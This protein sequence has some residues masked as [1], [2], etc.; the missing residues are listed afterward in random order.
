M[1]LE[2]LTYTSITGGCSIYTSLESSCP[3][4]SSEPSTEALAIR[5]DLF[6]AIPTPVAIPLAT[7][8]KR[9][10]SAYLLGSLLMSLHYTLLC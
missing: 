6:V 5:L 7:I 9:L 10:K 1:T 3:K 2:S 4:L 8:V